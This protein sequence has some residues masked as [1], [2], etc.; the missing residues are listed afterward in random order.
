L[1]ASDGVGS[2]DGREA[3]EREDTANIDCGVRSHDAFFAEDL[4]RLEFLREVVGRQGKC[5]RG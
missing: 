5:L 3:V 2:Y 1:G 4:E